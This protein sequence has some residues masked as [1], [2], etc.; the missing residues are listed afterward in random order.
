MFGE[1]SPRQGKSFSL[2]IKVGSHIRV[3]KQRG[4]RHKTK[5]AFFLITLFSRCGLSHVDEKI[6]FHSPH[7][8]PTNTG[9]P[10]CLVLTSPSPL[11]FKFHQKA[12]SPFRL[13]F[14]VPSVFTLSFIITKIPLLVVVQIASPPPPS[15]KDTLAIQAQ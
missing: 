13:Q 15:P 3:K 14:R 6:L 5:F 7:L 1:T 2:D 8:L 9:Q 12:A 11:R 4:G 10:A